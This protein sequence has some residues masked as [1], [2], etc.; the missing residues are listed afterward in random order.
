MAYKISRI[1]D[2][3]D[4]YRYLLVSYTY[5]IGINVLH[6]PLCNCINA[7]ICTYKIIITRLQVAS[8]YVIYVY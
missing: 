3:G 7:L 2:F 6:L 4:N 8:L 5:G 1:S